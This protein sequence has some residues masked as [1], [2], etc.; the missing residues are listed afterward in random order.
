[1]QIQNL[2]VFTFLFVGLF[3]LGD[4][5]NSSA[6]E[7]LSE[8]KLL[9]VAVPGIRDYLEYGGHG[10]LVFDINNSHQFVKRFPSGGLDEKGH[11]LNVKG[12]ACCAKTQRLY[13]TTTRTLLSFNLVSEKLLWEKAYEGGCDRLALSPDG[14][15]I[16]LPSLEKE[17]WHVVDAL[18]GTVR[19]KIV[20]NSG[21][22]NTIIGPDGK[23]AYLAGLKSPLLRV[24][25]T[26]KNEVVREIG[27]FGNVIR[28]FTING[29]QTLCYVN[30]N[31][32]LGFEIGDLRTGKVLHRI[33]VEGFSKGPTKRHGCPSHGIALT[34]DERELW[35]TDAFNS[36]LHIYDNKLSPPK[37]IE[38][39][40]L[41]DQPGWVSFSID[42]RYGYSST[43]DVIEVKT[44]KILAGLTDE[45]GAAVQ[46]EKLLEVDFANGM[47]VRAGNQFGIG[48]P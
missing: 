42:G 3:C 38:S 40:S 1:M 27:P 6:A 21:S 18:D 8:R 24:A 28:P 29:A 2:K 5:Q 7:K 30:V 15:F 43:G 19:K 41:R 48:Q 44:H 39:I 12:I 47:P 32:L 34:P 17:H 22:H 45:T 25:D 10:I 33:E 16:Y 20:T 35:L 9:Y 13:V 37:K 14:L 23:F 31:E 46:S 26:T 4:R 11:P 36:R